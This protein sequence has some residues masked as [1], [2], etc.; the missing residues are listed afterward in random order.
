MDKLIVPIFDRQYTV[1]LCQEK[2]LNCSCSYSDIW[3]LPCAHSICVATSLKP[4]W[5]GITHH[6][7]SVCWLKSYYLYSLPTSVIYDSEKQQ[8]S[9]EVF[10]TLRETENIC[11]HITKE[12]ISKQDIVA[13]E[14]LPVS[15]LEYSAHIIKC[16]NY[17]DS[18][19][20]ADFDPF[21]S[22]IDPTMSQ[23]T[24]INETLTRTE[25]EEVF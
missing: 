10:H 8:Q 24:E 17:P 15:L 14:D 1:K 20:W 5:L 18:D 13:T 4:H 3:G 22:N 21:M 9:K 16:Y 19:K 6:D 25:E 23:I 7:V 12:I 2:Q 11:I